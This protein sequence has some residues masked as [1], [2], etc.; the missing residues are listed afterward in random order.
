MLLRFNAGLGSFLESTLSG[1]NCR[2]I[3]QAS[4]LDGEASFL[5]LLRR[6]V[7]QNGSSPYLSLLQRAGIELGDLTMLVR[8]DGIEAALEKLYDAGVYIRLDEFKGLR[9][10]ERSGLNLIVKAEDFDNPLL[11]R[12]FEVATSG[13][14]GRRRRLAIDLDLLVYEA[15]YD[16]LVEESHGVFERPKAIWRP[17]PPGSSGLKTALRSAKCGS[18]LDRWFS[19]TP[20]SWRPS[21]W[22]S[23][24]FTLSAVLLGSTYESAIPVPEHVPLGEAWR[25][26]EWMSLLAEKGQPAYLS[27]PAS[28]VVR[29]CQAARDKRMDL[30]ESFFKVTGEPY[31]EGKQT[32]V[33]ACGASTFSGWSLA[34]CGS[35]AGGCSQRQAIDEMH[36]LAGK[37]ALIQRP[38]VLLGNAGTV[39][40][41]HLTTLRRETPKMMLNVDTGDYG[42]M[43]RRPCGCPLEW[44]GTH[45]HSIRNYEKLTASGMHIPGTDILELVDSVLPRIHGGGPASY[46]FVEETDVAGGGVT[47]VVS[48]SIPDLDEKAVVRDV[49]AYLS[50][51]SQAQRMMMNIWEQGA[52]LRVVRDEPYATATGKTP[53]VRIVAR[54]QTGTGA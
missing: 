54:H 34:E 44:L 2:Q 48:R 31:T 7:Y 51:R 3:A 19:P 30:E 11:R 24:V 1:E 8:Q 14:T 39:D 26:A 43:S 16:R 33:E 20:V 53:P 9:P 38:V 13:S 41:F 49:R 32:V 46:Q 18:P 15:A 17:V 50:R 45:V 12:D 22:N 28:S 25:V 6:A 29:V 5:D 37:V 40:A 47:I 35:V 27:A 21:A 23:T 10:I 4:V 42:V 52:T 36:V